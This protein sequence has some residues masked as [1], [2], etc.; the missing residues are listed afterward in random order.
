MNSPFPSCFSVADFKNLSGFVS[1][2]LISTL[3]PKVC[4]MKYPVHKMWHSKMAVNLHLETFFP[5]GIIWKNQFI[6]L[7]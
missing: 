2:M 5:S 7:I 3:L 4:S 1:T 6:I